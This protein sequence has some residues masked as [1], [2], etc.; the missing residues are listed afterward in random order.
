MRDLEGHRVISWSPMNHGTVTEVFY[1]F[2]SIRLCF[3]I[4]GQSKKGCNPEKEH[5]VLVE[6]FLKST[7]T[8]FFISWSYITVKNKMI[9]LNIKINFH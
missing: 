8:S 5:H 7:N 2:K 4:E 6:L 1:K 9:Y 3:T